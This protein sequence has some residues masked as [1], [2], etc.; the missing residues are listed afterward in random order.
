M[1]TE[2]KTRYR[3]F[4]KL[5]N[6]KPG[7]YVDRGDFTVLPEVS[8]EGGYGGPGEYKK[9]PAT[10]VVEYSLE[11]DAGLKE[12]R[13]ATVGEV[14]FVKP[15]SVEEAKPA[16]VAKSKRKAARVSEPVSEKPVMRKNVIYKGVFG[17]ITVP[18]EYAFIDGVAMILV[19]PSFDYAPPKGEEGFSVELDGTDYTVYNLD[20]KFV[21]PG[22][23]K[24][25]TILLVE[26]EA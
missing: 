16:A 22:Y 19:N 23:G 1:A 25:V 4:T 18:Y 13:R 17:E 6:E 9:Y 14:D 15:S 20:I 24:K 11:K 7:E 5:D 8:G 12:M 2:E 10:E 3:G 26:N 21:P